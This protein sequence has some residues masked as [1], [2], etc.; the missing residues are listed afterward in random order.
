MVNYQIRLQLEKEIESSHGS[1]YYI[2]EGEILTLNDLLYGLMLRSGNDASY[3]IAKYVGKD[4]D[5]FVNMMNEKA[6]LLQMKNTTFH[7]PNGLDEIDGNFS[8]AYE[9]CLTYK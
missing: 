3:A 6:H 7:N 1:G 5:S 9:Y 8:T 4:V 2:K